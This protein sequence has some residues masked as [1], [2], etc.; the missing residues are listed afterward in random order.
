MNRKTLLIIIGVVLSLCVATTFC[1]VSYY[2]I[3]RIMD[4]DG[5]NGGGADVTA[6]VTAEAPR[7]DG[8]EFETLPPSPGDGT[9]RLP[10]GLPPTLD[11]ALVQD[12][13]SAEYVVHL[14]SG[15]VR[16]NPRA[17]R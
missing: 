14:Y 1:G 8:G 3:S 9:L 4:G 11:P 10:G 12:S 17:R 13:T 7:T 15:L 6:T 16:L 5:G 2:V